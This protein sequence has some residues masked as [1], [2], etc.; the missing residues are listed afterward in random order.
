MEFSPL[1]VKEQMLNKLEHNLIAAWLL[2][3]GQVIL[4][5]E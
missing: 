2:H 4:S 1:F 5:E 3:K